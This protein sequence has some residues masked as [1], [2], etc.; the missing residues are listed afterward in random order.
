M[1]TYSAYDALAN[2]QWRDK[3]IGFVGLKYPASDQPCREDLGP[4]LKA[5]DKRKQGQTPNP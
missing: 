3:E 5:P 1:K 2:L 4:W